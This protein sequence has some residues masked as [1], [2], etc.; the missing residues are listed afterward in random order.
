MDG[1]ELSVSGGNLS[2]GGATVATT[3]NLTS[4]IDPH[5]NVN[6]ASS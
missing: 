6:S 5:L 1:T 4:N 3:T 2:V